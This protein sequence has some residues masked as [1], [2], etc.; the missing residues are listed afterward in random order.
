ME[1]FLN[2]SPNGSKSKQSRNNEMELESQILSNSNMNLFHEAVFFDILSQTN[3]SLSHYK[4]PESDDLNIL[5]NNV[6]KPEINLNN[7]EMMNQNVTQLVKLPLNVMPPPPHKIVNY[8]N[9]KRY[10]PRDTTKP[11]DN[12]R[13]ISPKGYESDESCTSYSS[14]GTPPDNGKF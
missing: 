7:M 11:R 14:R 1:K 13:P 5:N 3:Y 12:Y 6:N 10:H 9:I 2:I 4:N 8:N